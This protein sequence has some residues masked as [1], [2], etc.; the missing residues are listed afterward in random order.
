MK[1][2]AEKK[3]SKY[4]VVLF[5]IEHEIILPE[6]KKVKVIKVSKPK[7]KVKKT[8]ETSFVSSI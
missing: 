5:G 8:K 2:L 3:G 4:F 1:L 7:K 6:V